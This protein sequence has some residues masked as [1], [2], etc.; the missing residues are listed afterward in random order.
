M[1]VMILAGFAV[2]GVTI[3]NR[4]QTMASKSDVDSESGAGFGEVDVEIPQGTRLR[5]M[6]T[7][8]D[9]LVLWLETGDSTQ[10]R[11]LDLATGAERG[12]FRLDGTLP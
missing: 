6:T 11:V 7:S 9:R 8:G 1:G 4:L 2:I 10:I 12:V 3:Y 5:R